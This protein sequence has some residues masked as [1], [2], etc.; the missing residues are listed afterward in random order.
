[1]IF[2]EISQPNTK[3]LDF[4][5]NSMFM[6]TQ[7][8]QELKLK[9]ECLKALLIDDKNDETLTANEER[10]SIDRFGQVMTWFGPIKGQ[11]RRGILD[12][13]CVN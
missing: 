13:V 3:I 10:V 2:L 11:N 7:E 4:M 9:I 8:M 6:P 5:K 1:M 12:E